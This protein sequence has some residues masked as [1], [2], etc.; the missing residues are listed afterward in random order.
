MIPLGRPQFAMEAAGKYGAVPCEEVVCP[1]R[2]ESV[3][4][5]SRPRRRNAA[6][7]GLALLACGAIAAGAQYS[8]AVRSSTFAAQ[9]DAVPLNCLARMKTE[10]AL[11]GF[12]F[13]NFTDVQ[14]DL[15]QLVA[16]DFA[17]T[18]SLPLFEGRVSH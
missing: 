15:L 8:G 7:V 12:G 17:G 10:L 1:A 9:T 16:A 4:V 11:Q 3:S 5:P 14:V 6:A 13:A 18:V 2:S